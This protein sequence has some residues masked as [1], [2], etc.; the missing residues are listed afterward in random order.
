MLQPG[1]KGKLAVM[2]DKSEIESEKA[3]QDFK[4]SFKSIVILIL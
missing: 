3:I 2:F 1:G 4:V